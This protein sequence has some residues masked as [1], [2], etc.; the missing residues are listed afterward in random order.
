[1]LDLAR[2]R[3]ALEAVDLIPG[4]RSRRVPGSRG[5]AL[6]PRA[7]TGAIY[8][9]PG[10][11]GRPDVLAEV[12]GFRD[13]EAILA[14]F[15]E[16]RGVSPGDPVLPE[17]LTDQQRVGDEFLG[18]IVDALGEPIDGGPAPAARKLLP[19]Y[20]PA[21][22]PLTR[23]PITAP[24]PT[25]VGVLDAMTAVGRGQRLGIFA[26]PGVG[27]STLMGM[28][29]RFAASEVN[30]ICLVGERGR[31]V[32]SFIEHELGPEGMARS[33]LVVA[34]GDASPILR[35]RAAFLA[36]TLAEYFRERGRQVILMMDSLTRL[37]HALREI[38]LAAGEP[39]TTRGYPPSVFS[40]LPRL[41]ERAGNAEGPGTM[42]AF[43]TVLVDGD[44]MTEPIADA[45]RSIL[46]GHVIL[47]RRVAEAGRYPAVD[48]PRSLSR[49][50]SELITP[51][52]AEL[53]RRVR[54]VLSGYEEI[55]DLVQVGAY[56]QGNDPGVDRTIQLFPRLTDHFK[57]GRAERRTL[58]ST[59][60][61]LL[62]LLGP[63]DARAKP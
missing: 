5:E 62:A 42:T 2:V 52:H 27:K 48:V 6:L 54:E 35:V 18:R 46:D 59:L 28:L 41:L 56:R 63:A 43:Y 50:A 7:Q 4:G 32:R 19:L 23:M 13:R 44:D 49:L 21:P 16:P 12:I 40:A 37:A 10:H 58:D 11:G 14:P 24:L 55:R 34:T 61:A 51:A 45:A 53:A 47:S 29:A 8:R 36:T 9:I 33:V 26:G 15:H 38:G 1:V 30:V 25:G 22:N 17:G 20:R 57:Q 39:P 60:G 31:E 3:R